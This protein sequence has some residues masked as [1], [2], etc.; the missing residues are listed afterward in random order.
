MKLEATVCDQTRGGYTAGDKQIEP[1]S[2]VRT[3]AEQ[4]GYP[5]L[6]EDLPAKV[7]IKARN[8][9]YLDD[10]RANQLSKGQQKKC[11]P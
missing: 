4:C 8:S 9:K 6:C 1:I 5:E 11:L 2:L 7:A 3:N 10:S